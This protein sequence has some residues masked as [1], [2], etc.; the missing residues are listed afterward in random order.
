MNTFKHSFFTG[1][2]GINTHGYFNYLFIISTSSWSIRRYS[3][4]N[5]HSYIDPDPYYF[6]NDM[7]E[8]I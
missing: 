1:S 2:Q 5:E 6:E 3:F 7:K 4:H 8:K